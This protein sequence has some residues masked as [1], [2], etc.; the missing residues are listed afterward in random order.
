M[1]KYE[2]RKQICLSQTSREAL[3][4]L[5]SSVKY[6]KLDREK[7]EKVVYDYDLINLQYILSKENG[8][9]K[10]FFCKYFEYCIKKE[11]EELQEILL[12]DYIRIFNKLTENYPD[13]LDMPIG[14]Y[15]HCFAFSKPKIIEVL[16]MFYDLYQDKIPDDLK[17]IFQYV[18]NDNP[19]GF[20]SKIITD[21][22]I[23]LNPTDYKGDPLIFLV[24]T[25][26]RTY[27]Y[28]KIADIFKEIKKYLTVYNKLS[29]VVRSSFSI[30]SIESRFTAIC[31]SY[32]DG[33]G[34]T[35][36]D[37]FE[38]E[39]KAIRIAKTY[40]DPMDD[41]IKII[42]DHVKK[43]IKDDD[44]MFLKY[45]YEKNNIDRNHTYDVNLLR[46]KDPAL[47]EK[48]RAKT[49]HSNKVKF[50]TVAAK[51]RKIKSVL[52]ENK[53]KMSIVDMMKIYNPHTV[54]NLNGFFTNFI[55]SLEDEVKKPLFSY[56]RRNR[57]AFTVLNIDVAMK[58]KVNIGGK[59]LTNE[60]KENIIQYIKDNNLPLVQ[61]LYMELYRLYLKG[62][63]DLSVPFD[64]M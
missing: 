30:Y 10:F 19:E 22:D 2:E 35:A 16:N 53:F 1:T 24:C 46:E 49:D 42:S 55:N 40:K 13:Y 4:E 14:H 28:N 37:R 20:L 41:Q 50:A 48:Y 62:E 11:D 58:A 34:S 8:D 7:L 25:N 64:E 27:I 18:R 32:M 54:E 45:Y 29:F 47:Y 36:Y 15:L 23:K 61:G 17:E 59:I 12:K 56:Y 26:Q 43:F 3:I 63:L 38:N 57:S 39:R 5:L 21:E 52:Y 60:D 33:I 31:K 44:S 9:R 51:A 6:N